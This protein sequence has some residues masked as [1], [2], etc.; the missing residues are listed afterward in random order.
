MLCGPRLRAGGQ[1][2]KRL[3][4][5]SAGASAAFAQPQGKFGAW[6]PSQMN[7]VLEKEAGDVGKLLLP[8]L[9]SW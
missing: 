4:E 3:C 9:R 8:V 6:F 7:S 5:I 2:G 1:Q